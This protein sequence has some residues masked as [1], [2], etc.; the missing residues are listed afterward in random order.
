M[1]GIDA[2]ALGIPS[3]DDYVDQ[4]C[5][6]MGITAIDNWPF[7]LAFS[8]F[9]MAAICQGVAKRGLDGNASSSRA[10][11]YQQMVRPLAQSGLD[12]TS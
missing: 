9:R 11:G 5:K 4:Y 6:R 1:G 8:F 2:D 3:E 10:I 7:Y 12:V